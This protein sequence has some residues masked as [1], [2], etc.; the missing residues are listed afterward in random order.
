MDYPEYLECLR[1]NARGARLGRYGTV[2][3]GGREYPLLSLHTEGRRRLVITSGFHGEEP[4]GP[5]TLMRRLPEVL[6]F[7]RE[8]DVALDVFPC[9]NPSGFE[10]GTRY[11]RSGEKPNNDFLRY[12]VSPGVWKDQLAEG[13]AFL[14]WTLHDGGPKETQALR[15]AL[16]ALPVPDAALDIHQDNYISGSLTYAYVFGDSGPYLPLMDAASR[17]ARV[18]ASLTVDE[19]HRTDGEGLIRHHDGSV[20]DYYRRRGVPYTAALETTTRTP[21]EASE[22]VNLIWL[23]GFIELAARGG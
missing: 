9:I 4:S 3:E 14:R 6:A 15:S 22:A 12:E 5:L 10:A 19:H 16:Y 1:M 2:V 13:E 20:T 11:N 23:R 8:R 7:A 21:P 17:H 18:A